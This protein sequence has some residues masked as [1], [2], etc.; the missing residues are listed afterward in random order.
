MSIDFHRLVRPVD[1]NRLIL[2][3]YYRLYRLI[4]I[5]Y[6]RLYRLISDDRLLSIGHARNHTTVSGTKSMGESITPEN[7]VAGKIK[8]RINRHGP[9]D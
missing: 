3:D 5:D 4:L 7:R 8:R 6:Y 9:N 1:I 2:I